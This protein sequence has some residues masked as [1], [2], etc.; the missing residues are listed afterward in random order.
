MRDYGKLRALGR[1]VE[2]AVGEDERLHMVSGE[3]WGGWWR[4]LL[5]RMIEK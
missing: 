2:E 5:G 1:M 3:H 4:K